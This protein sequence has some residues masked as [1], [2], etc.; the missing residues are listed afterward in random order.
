MNVTY[1]NIIPDRFD[2]QR[3]ANKYA[4]VGKNHDLNMM[5]SAFLNKTA[6]QYF[7]AVYK[8]PVG[9]REFETEQDLF[10]YISGNEYQKNN[11]RDD[12]LIFAVLVPFN[13]TNDKNFD[14]TIYISSN[15]PTQMPDTRFFATTAK[16]DKD[17]YKGYANNGFAT[18]QYWLSQFV[19]FIE[20]GD[21]APTIDIFMAEG[22]TKAYTQN[23]FMD[24]IG[25]SL[26]LFILLIFI[27]PQYRFIGMVTSEKASRAREGMKIMG[28]KDSP[29]WLSWFIYYFG[30]STAIAIICAFIF[31][32]FIFTNSSFVFLFL[33]V[34]LYGMSIFSYSMLI[35]SF[36]QRPRV[37]CILATLIHFITYFAV[38]P[39]SDYG[40]STGV[41]TVFSFVPNIAMAL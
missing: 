38:V 6:L 13:A 21:N 4:I 40:I 16:P 31:V 36:L 20:K 5:L 3:F 29:Y 41:K 28:L 15:F 17:N 1:S 35:C 8:L 23:D 22:K 37:A 26:A 33:F 24:N 10:D 39:I 14:F 19:L 7:G 25:A 34:W 9:Y 30:V 12:S 27:A 2:L 18:L 11:N 32:L